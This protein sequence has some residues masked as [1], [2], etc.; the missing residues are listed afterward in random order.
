M[1][2]KSWGV[3]GVLREYRGAVEYDISSRFPGRFPRGLRS[4]GDTCTLQELARLIEILRADP[5]SALAAAIEGWTHPVSREA[6]I[7]MDL[8]D[9]EAIKSGAKKPPKYERP[10]KSAA[11]KQ[12]LG[13]APMSRD[14]LDA[15]LGRTPAPAPPV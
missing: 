7:L 5:S 3:L 14:E 15:R 12:H 2:G 8:W 4:V 9:L 13:D 10:W 1:D 11:S 6:A